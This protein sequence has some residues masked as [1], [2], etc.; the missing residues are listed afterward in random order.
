MKSFK[1]LDLHLTRHEDA[2]REV[3]RF[4]EDNWGC[5][6][7]LDIITGNSS[8]MREIVIKVLDEYHLCW[9]IGRPFDINK[10]YIVIWPED[11]N[12]V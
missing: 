9:S 11:I 1:S 3:I 2:E 4:I 12:Y 10:G 8:Q 5:E 7:S 6:Y